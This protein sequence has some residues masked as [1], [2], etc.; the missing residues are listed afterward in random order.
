MSTQG[1]ASRPTEPIPHHG[2]AR[3][4][5]P[6]APPGAMKPGEMTIL[7]RFLAVVGVTCS[8]IVL[9]AVVYTIIDEQLLRSAPAT[10]ASASEPQA[11]STERPDASTLV[12]RPQ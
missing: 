8:S 5:L 12:E 7:E 9:V 2:L 4:G 6:P 1:S 10:H 3:E 11:P